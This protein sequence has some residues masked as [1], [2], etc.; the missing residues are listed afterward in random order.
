[1]FVIFSP[2]RRLLQ[3]MILGF[4]GG[5]VIDGGVYHSG[6]H[7][8]WFAVGIGAVLEGAAAWLA[9]TALRWIWGGTKIYFRG[10]Q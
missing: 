1:M 8:L 9:W 6:P 3:A 10:P 4:G 7:P 2:W 5:L